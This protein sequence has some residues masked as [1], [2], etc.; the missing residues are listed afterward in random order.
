MS[1][2]MVDMEMT[3]EQ[4]LDTLT[5][6]PVS[7]RPD[8]P[9]GLRICLCNDEIEKLNLDFTEAHVGGLIYGKFLGKITSV[10]LNDDEGNDANPRQ[11]IEI[12]ITGLCIDCDDDSEGY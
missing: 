7:Q 2:V 1:G 8:Y 4:K 6:I 10:S 11:R 9:W 5:P 3:D 12:Q